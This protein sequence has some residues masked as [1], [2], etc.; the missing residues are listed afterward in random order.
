MSASLCEYT[1]SPLC[2]SIS[3]ITRYNILSCWHCRAAYRHVLCIS[4]VTLYVFVF[5]QVFFPVFS[6]SIYLCAATCFF[7]TLLSSAKQYI[8]HSGF[9]DNSIVLNFFFQLRF[10]IGCGFFISSIKRTIRWRYCGKLIR[11]SFLG[12]IILVLLNCLL[13]LE[14][15]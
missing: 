8:V 3:L 4:S 11:F 10:I 2:L 9:Y 6:P 7:S 5:L 15:H 13:I 1:L 14:F 12:S